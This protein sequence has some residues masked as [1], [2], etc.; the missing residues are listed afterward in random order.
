[1]PYRFNVFTA[2]FDYYETGGSVTPPTIDGVLLTETNDY[3]I[4]E[5]GDYLA[6]E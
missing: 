4:T 2:N 3:L 6:W 1:M 5:A